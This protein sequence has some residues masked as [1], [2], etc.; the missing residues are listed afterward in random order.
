MR[1][2]KIRSKIRMNKR[3]IGA[4]KRVGQIRVRNRGKQ[5]VK[6]GVSRDKTK[7]K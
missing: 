6:A 3:G 1:L 2:K 5:G 7:T 4:L